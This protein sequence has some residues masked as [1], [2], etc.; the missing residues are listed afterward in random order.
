MNYPFRKFLELESTKKV[1]WSYVA[2]HQEFWWSWFD[3]DLL[4]KLFVD[5]NFFS[6]NNVTMA[7]QEVLMKE[8]YEDQVF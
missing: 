4:I 3:Q 1:Q 6:Q 2:N 8:F 5:Q 7:P